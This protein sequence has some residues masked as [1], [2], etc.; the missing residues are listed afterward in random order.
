MV[1]IQ[2]VPVGLAKRVWQDLHTQIVGAM[3][4]HGS[5]DANDVLLL[6]QQNRLAM[7][8]AIVDNELLGCFIIE[9]VEFPRKKVCNIVAVAGRNGATR[10]WINEM[11][12][13]LEGW[14]LERGCD[15]IAGIG[16]KGWMVAK[17][18]G[19]KTEQRAILVKDLTDER[20][21]RYSSTNTGP[22]ERHTTVP[23]N[24]VQ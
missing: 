17:E 23:E 18:F 5:M 6:L 2:I 14:A 21:R 22:L 10:S 12:Q 9:V 7:I 13:Y 20:R 15:S 1:E 11:L 3:R 8:A 24:R 4:Y 16:R 19:W